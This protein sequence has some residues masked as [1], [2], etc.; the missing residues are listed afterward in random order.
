M[1]ELG[2]ER[3]RIGKLTGQINKVF[4]KLKEKEEEMKISKKELGD[5][6][7]MLEEK[8]EEIKNEKKNEFEMYENKIK[9]YE[10][11]IERFKIQKK[12]GLVLC[13][14]DLAG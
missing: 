11:M 10:Q 5:L 7:S 14:K 8:E 12:E 13:L 9:K 3:K 4:S 2:N 6:S 1:K